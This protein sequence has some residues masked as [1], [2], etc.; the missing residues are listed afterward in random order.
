MQLKKA[1]GCFDNTFVLLHILGGQ[2]VE[3]FF[4]LKLFM[5]EKTDIEERNGIKKNPRSLFTFCV[6]VFCEIS[7]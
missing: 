2:Y 5:Y 4:L 7:C 6:L 3:I 1:K